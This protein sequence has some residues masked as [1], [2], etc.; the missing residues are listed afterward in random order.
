M[1]HAVPAI[2]S[3]R[4]YAEAGGLMSYGLPDIPPIGDVVPRFWGN[5][6]ILATLVVQ[7]KESRQK[8]RSW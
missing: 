5:G 7:H 2:Y 8:G 1:R 6:S 4:E 3:G